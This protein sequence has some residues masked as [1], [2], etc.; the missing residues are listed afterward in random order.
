MRY[1]LVL[2][3]LALTILG[4]SL[5]MPV[6]AQALKKT[7]ISEAEKAT[8]AFLK[9]SK[10]KPDYK[11]WIRAS[12]E[13]QN[14]SKEERLKIEELETHRLK[15]GFKEFSFEEDFLKITTNVQL[16]MKEKNEKGTAML[17]FHFPHQDEDYIP[18]FPYAHA[19]LWISLLVQDLP[20]F[21]RLKLTEEQYVHIKKFLP[22]ENE[23]YDGKITMRVRPVTADSTAPFKLDG[24][25]QWLMMGDVAFLKCTTSDPQTK[26]EKDLWEYYAPWYLT[27][28]ENFLLDELE[29]KK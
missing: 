18:Y 8:F 5:Q 28:T 7:Q 27:E 14:A 20:Q 26:Q 4:V 6:H 11:S 13:Y 2:S 29:S 17:I 25:D 21:A 16:Q 12:K 24:V 22:N 3:I 1:F 23:I 19:G 15:W 10:A 9:L